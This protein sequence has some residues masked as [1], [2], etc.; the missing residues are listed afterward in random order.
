MGVLHPAVK[1]SNATI[2]VTDERLRIIHQ[3][4]GFMV[5]KN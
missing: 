2:N 5:E 1:P 3:T 4:L